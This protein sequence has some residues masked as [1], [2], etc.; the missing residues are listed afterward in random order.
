LL[1]GLYES[2]VDLPKTILGAIILVE[3]IGER[4]LWV[5]SICI[6]QDD[7]AHK[8]ETIPF[9]GMI[10]GNAL[11]SIVAMTSHKA[12]HGLFP[13]NN[14]QARVGELIKPGLTLQPV[15]QGT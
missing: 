2:E 13:I 8:K 14:R 9:M 11:F 10:Y 7:M 12:D 5:D 3:Q 15:P 4:F 6:L 1:G